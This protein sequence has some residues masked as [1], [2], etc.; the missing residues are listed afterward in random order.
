MM[1]ATPWDMSPAWW[2]PRAR[3]TVDARLFSATPADTAGSTLAGART[4]NVGTGSVS[5]RESRGTR[6][7][8]DCFRFTL[9]ADSF[10]SLSLTGLT[11]GAN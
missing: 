9:S 2:A 11:K 7:T 10:V 5:E 8:T 3:P 6:D 1:S 4:L